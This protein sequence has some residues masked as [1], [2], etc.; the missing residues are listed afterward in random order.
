MKVDTSLEATS[1][2]ATAAE[3]KLVE[4]LLTSLIGKDDVASKSR[5][6]LEANSESEVCQK[7][8]KMRN[9]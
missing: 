8:L 2:E 4:S 1:L 6:F 3:N 7:L 9:R 5:A